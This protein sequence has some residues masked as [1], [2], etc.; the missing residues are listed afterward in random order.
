MDG[1]CGD[2]TRTAFPLK[3]AA[4]LSTSSYQ[5]TKANSTIERWAVVK[6]MKGLYY[7][8]TQ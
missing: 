5:R 4:L 7:F 2:I 8:L 6:G 1:N 3:I